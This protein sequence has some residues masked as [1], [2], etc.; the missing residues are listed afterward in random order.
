M[1]KEAERSSFGTHTTRISVSTTSR[2]SLREGLRPGP[3]SARR[4]D[5]SSAPISCSGGSSLPRSAA[6][7][8][9]ELLER[10]AAGFAVAERAARGRA[11]NVVEPRV[12]RAAVRT[13]EGVAL[14]L[15]EFRR[16]DIAG[17]WGIEA[18]AAELLP[19]LRR[20]AVGRP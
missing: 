2:T 15:D 11:E 12:A 4:S 17:R 8:R 20:D 9:L 7:N 6:L 5:R 14:E 1:S 19:P 3:C 13:A 10:L 16:R 18:G